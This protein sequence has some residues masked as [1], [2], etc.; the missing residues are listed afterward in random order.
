MRGWR[1]G[2]AA[3]R[4]H[5]GRQGESQRWER[6]RARRP[7]AQSAHIVLCGTI[8]IQCGDRPEFLQTCLPVPHP[9]EQSFNLVM[10]CRLAI[11]VSFPL[12]PLCSLYLNPRL[13]EAALHS[14]EVLMNS[15]PAGHF[16]APSALTA[17]CVPGCQQ[18][19]REGSSGRGE[20]SNNGKESARRPYAHGLVWKNCKFAL[21]LQQPDAGRDE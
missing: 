15:K 13:S 3:A 1:R 14:A 19:G 16:V 11:Q 20:R 10:S 9:A 17:Y 2:R 21:L 7:Y 4:A 8:A 18:K 5:G 12:P 6:V